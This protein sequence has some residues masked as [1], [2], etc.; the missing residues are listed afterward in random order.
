MVEFRTLLIII[1]IGTC[2]SLAGCGTTKSSSGPRVDRSLVRNGQGTTEPQPYVKERRPYEEISGVKSI[3]YGG[4]KVD[5]SELDQYRMSEGA[6]RRA[7]I[8]SSVFKSE[9]IPRIVRAI[10]GWAGSEQ[11][12]II[13]KYDEFGGAFLIYYYQAPGK[14]ISL[15]IK[16]SI[17]PGK[18]LFK[19]LNI[20]DGTWAGETYLFNLN[21]DLLDVIKHGGKEKLF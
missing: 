18:G 4:G 10:Q 8:Q 17:T 20:L 15:A 13:G 7:V 9:D 11:R 19:Y 1:I 21:G 12:Y 16:R 2:A 6:I 14:E 3:E 5:T